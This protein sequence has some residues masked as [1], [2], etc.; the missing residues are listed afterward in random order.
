MRS[1]KLHMTAPVLPTFV[2][3]LTRACVLGLPLFLFYR[4]DLGYPLFAEF[5][6]EFFTTFGSKLFQVFAAS[7]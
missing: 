4:S 3:L 7:L 2:R 5:E 6:L 1:M